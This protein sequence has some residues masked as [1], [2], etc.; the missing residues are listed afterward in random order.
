MI[1]FFTF[2]HLNVFILGQKTGNLSR[3]VENVATKGDCF[4]LCQEYNLC[5]WFTHIESLSL[6]SLLVETEGI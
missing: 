3:I 1:G 5:E 6:C 2:I 4:K